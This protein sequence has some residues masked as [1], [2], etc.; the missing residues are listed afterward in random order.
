MDSSIPLVITVIPN[1]NL[2]KDLG[3]CLDSL[4]QS[5]YPANQVVVVDNGSAD[6]SLE[7]VRANYPEVC[8][9]A[10]PENC[11]YAAAL[12]TGIEYGLT[13][14]PGYI[15]ALNNDT[16]VEPDCIAILVKT[17]EADPSIGMAA[18][19]ILLYNQLDHL[20]GLGDRRYRWLPMPVGFGYRQKDSPRVSG[21]LDFDYVTGC[22]QMIRAGAI[23]TAGLYDT[24]FFMY[25]EDSDFCRRVRDHNFRIVC[26]TAA[27]LYHKAAVSTDKDKAANIFLRARN[28]VRFYRRYR[29]GPLPALT[30]LAIGATALWRTAGFVRQGRQDLARSYWQGLRQGWRE[31]LPPPEYDW[32]QVSC[33]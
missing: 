26:V 7:F 9:L 16:I 2:K 15:F 19:K 4:R 17:L 33:T 31:P 8:C 30:Y 3:E 21:L 5:A 13:K 22:A 11:G 27:V 20:Y 14:N 24:S 10:L 6:G 1:W 29:H 23:R 25:C 28:R 18:P 32:K 12:N